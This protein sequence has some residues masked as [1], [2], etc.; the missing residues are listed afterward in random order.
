MTL[1]SLTLSQYQSEVWAADTTSENSGRLRNR[2]S[3]SD[4]VQLVE[5]SDTNRGRSIRSL[6]GLEN[7]YEGFSEILSGNAPIKVLPDLTA[8]DRDPNFVGKEVV[9]YETSEEE[10]QLRNYDEAS[11]NNNKHGMDKRIV[12]GSVATPFPAFT[13]WLRHIQFDDSWHFAGCGGALI[14]NCHILSAAHCSADSR[15]ELPH[16]VFIGAYK[17][18]SGDNDGMPFGFGTIA[19]THI[20]PNFSDDGNKNDVAILVLDECVD[21]D[22]H[23]PMRVAD[24]SLM[25]TM[26]TGTN[27]IVMGFGLIDEQS[28]EQTEVL[29]QVSVPF[30]PKEDCKNYYGNQIQDDMICAGRSQGGRDSCQGDSGGPLIVDPDDPSPTII[31]TVSWG[32][33]CAQPNKPGVYANAAHHYCY[34]KNIVC[35]HPQTDQSIDLCYGYDPDKDGDDE[36]VGNGSKCRAMNEHCF[37]SLDC[38]GNLSCHARD[39]VCKA[40]SSNG[41]GAAGNTNKSSVRG[42]SPYRQ[43]PGRGG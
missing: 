11:T 28:S 18:Y 34:I 4:E 3:S 10:Q 2:K 26:K 5:P 24:R 23:P 43:R 9:I 21:L 38:C 16:G 17:P 31:G 14:S 13:M 39:N 41:G 30:I 35:S 27:A 29:N 42:T 32:V 37:T 40:P 22:E 33:G 20:H 36:C 7:G 1:L 6:Y 19:R 25:K 15:E 12:G 8:P